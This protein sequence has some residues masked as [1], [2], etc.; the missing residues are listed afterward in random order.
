MIT[1]KSQKDIGYMRD[2]GRIL[3]ETF[4]ELEKSI[5]PG[6]TTGEL[7]KIAEDYIIK[8]GS[9]PAFK[10]LYGFP[11]SICASVNDE[12]VHGIPGSRVLQDG[13]IISVD[14]GSE[15]NGFYGDSAR[16]FPVGNISDEAKDLLKVTEEALF[17]G[18]EQ[19]VD[20][21]HV[22]DI[23][24]AVQEYVEAHGYSVV[25]DYVGHGIGRQMHESPQ[26]PNYGRPGHG[27]R[28]K[29]GMALAIEPMVNAGAYDVRVLDNDWTVVTV[30]GKI[31]AHF[32]HSVA[33]TKG[34]PIILT[35][36]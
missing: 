30:D 10:G 34:K 20:G 8:R 4:K 29:E 28:L 11:A 3:G 25:R 13:D 24:H 35:K 31:S 7:D 14:L 17:K 26:V 23:S 22:S 33:I 6:I 16:T 12:V 2:A 5:K 19:A 1:I 36:A 15:V 32:E 21:N 18:I 27:P 9:R